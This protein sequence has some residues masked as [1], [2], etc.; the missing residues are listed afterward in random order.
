MSEQAVAAKAD[1]EA[2]RPINVVTWKDKLAAYK[3]RPLSMFLLMAVT[4]SAVITV[5]VLGALVIYILANGIMNLSPELF[6]WKYTTENVSMLPAIINTFLMTALSLLIA[7]PIGICSAI[8][9]VE[10]A[11]RGNK[12][13][14]IV[15][16]TTE[17]LSGIPSIV[18][19]LFGHL[20]FVIAFGWGLSFFGG[21]LTLSIMVLPTIMRTTE[22]A[23]LSVPDSYREGSFGLGAGRL[24][25][26]FKVV[27]PSAVPGILSGVILAIGRIVGETAA[28]IFTS[29]T[30]AE[31]PKSLFDSGC[32]LAV[33]MYKLLSEGLYT[34]QA[35][36]TAVVLLVMVVII[37]AAS[38]KLAKK[39]QAK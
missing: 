37:N 19:G 1:M 34:K 18:Y 17:T 16:I 39:L 2:I 31:I 9:L 29:G 14:S 27:L 13:V 35:Y 20:M 30:T 12:L 26:I 15:R 7:V 33:H 21:A 23:L 36:A 28:L 32:T 10:Y 5:G 38:G 8:Y 25:T 3:K 11:K 22:E 24:R 4:V 6:A